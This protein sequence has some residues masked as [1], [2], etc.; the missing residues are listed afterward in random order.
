MAAAKKFCYSIAARAIKDKAFGLQLAAQK[1]YNIV[2][3][4]ICNIYNIV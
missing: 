2:Y 3:N 1:V 4:I